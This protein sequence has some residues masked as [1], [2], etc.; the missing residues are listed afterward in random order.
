M[1]ELHRLVIDVNLLS[2]KKTFAFINFLGR[3][4]W[5]SFKLNE[6][7]AVAGNKTYQ[8]I[9]RRDVP[10]IASWCIR[11]GLTVNANQLLG[12]AVEFSYVYWFGCECTL[13]LPP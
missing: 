9:E 8:W 2:N 4:V 3:A 6:V 5:S 13:E 1:R 10:Y 11:A 7:F 12:E